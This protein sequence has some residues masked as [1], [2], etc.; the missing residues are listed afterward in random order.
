MWPELKECIH[1]IEPH[2]FKL[3]VTMVEKHTDIWDDILIDFPNTHVEVVENRGYDIG[4]FVHIINQVNLDDYSYIVKLHTKRD[5]E[6]GN[7]GFRGLDASKWRNALLSFIKTTEVF[8]QYLN[9]FE[10]NPNI[11]MQAHHTVIVHHDFFDEKAKKRMKQYLIE[12]HLP[13]IKYAFVAGTMF[14]ARASIF[15]DIQNLH[16]TF[17][18]FPDPK[19][20][21]KTQLAHVMERL[22][23]YF[24]Y[25][26]KFVIR[27]GLLKPRTE[28]QYH[29]KEYI[30]IKFIYPIIRFFYQKKITKSGKMIVK[31]CKIPIFVRK[32]K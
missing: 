15:K 27:D 4:P 6:I 10:K 9:V 21:H 12:K 17:S 8:N 26:N 25:K 24:V 22:F 7:T 13:N 11:G 32:V 16:L 29:Q 19:G 23:G 30:K 28:K 5:L 31:I 2:P 3:F 1:N 20:E 18:D 14:I